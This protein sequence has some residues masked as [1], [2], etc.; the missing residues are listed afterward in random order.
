MVE[1]MVEHQ[2]MVEEMVEHQE[3]VEEM[4][5]HQLLHLLHLVSDWSSRD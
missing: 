1:E 2:E 5:E 3:M 4:V